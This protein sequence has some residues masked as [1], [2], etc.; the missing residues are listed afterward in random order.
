M[1]APSLPEEK[2]EETKKTRASR[3]KSML[4]ML[5]VKRVQDVFKLPNL[6]ARFS[7]ISGI[8]EQYKKNL[9]DILEKPLKDRAAYADTAEAAELDWMNAAE[10]LEAAE[11]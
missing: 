4:K 6:G 9:L 1:S 8:S 5:G 2:S 10:E 11:S 7:N 3:I